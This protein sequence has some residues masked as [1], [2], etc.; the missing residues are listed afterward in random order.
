MA[1]KQDKKGG[2]QDNE[3]ENER[4][5]EEEQVVRKQMSV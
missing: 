4:R 3:T 1:E 2:K 5:A